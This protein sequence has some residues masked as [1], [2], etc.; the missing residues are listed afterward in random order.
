MERS[1][2]YILD[3][4]YEHASVICKLLAKV[5]LSQCVSSVVLHDPS[6]NAK[7][8]ALRSLASSSG[9]PP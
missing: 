1:S 2:K 8:R 5:S 3:Q 9:L 6:N 4:I 7:L